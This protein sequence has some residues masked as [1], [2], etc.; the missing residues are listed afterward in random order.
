MS[1]G[2]FAAKQIKECFKQNNFGAEF[3]KGYDKQIYQKYY[4]NY[5]M[6]SR[7]TDLYYK[8]PLLMDLAVYVAGGLNKLRYRLF[9]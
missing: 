5:K 1:S 6:K 7:I 2:R 3:M 4:R 8:Y 9:K